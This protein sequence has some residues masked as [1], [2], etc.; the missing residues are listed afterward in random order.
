MLG[1]E[2]V[3]KECRAGGGAAGLNGGG[4][5]LILWCWWVGFVRA[6]AEGKRESSVGAVLWRPF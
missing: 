1:G 5:E 4:S 2:G 3:G 6:C